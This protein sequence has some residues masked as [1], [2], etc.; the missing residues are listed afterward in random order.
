MIFREL[1]G[2][3][4]PLLIPIE[5]SAH[6]VPW[7]EEV[8][9]RCF[10]VGYR[11]WGLEYA[12]QLVGFIIYSLHVGEC[13]ILNLCVHA[14][15]QHQGFG[16]AL[17]THGLNKAK[18]QGAEMAFLEVRRSNEHALLLYDKLGFIQIGERKGYY[19]NPGKTK[20]DA[21]I[22]AKDLRV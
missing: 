5:E 15:H 11:C 7:T 13:H 21:L 12:D 1:H 4:L 20:E 19:P 10:Q 6:L 14:Q 8:F 2:D 3:S 16:R 18:Q 22:L 17:L 9:Q